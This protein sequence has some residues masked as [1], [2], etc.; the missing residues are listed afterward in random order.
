M[1]VAACMVVILV[2]A[3]SAQISDDAAVA[4]LTSVMSRDNV[5]T[6]D[7]AI[8]IIDCR[9]SCDSV[10]LALVGGTYRLYA[11][12]SVIGDEVQL[13]VRDNGT[14]AFLGRFQL[15]SS[16]QILHGTLVV[17][18]ATILMVK[19]QRA[20]APKRTK[21]ITYRIAIAI[22]GPTRAG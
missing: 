14:G 21:N 15:R 9:S 16:A 20:S 1:A 10:T 22:L 18:A 3:L 7:A 11:A 6:A 17:P 19:A 8:E 13:D 5:A 4:N 2:A 12:T